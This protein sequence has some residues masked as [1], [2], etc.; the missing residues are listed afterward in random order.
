MT[1]NTTP[2]KPEWFELTDGD[3]P[4]AQ[5]KKVGKKLPAIAVLVTGAVIASGAFFANASEKNGLQQGPLQNE[6]SS[7]TSLPPHD[8]APNSGAPIGDVNGAFDPSQNGSSI[9]PG[10]LPPHK[11]G[12]GITQPGLPPQGMQPPV[13][14]LGGDDDDDRFEHREGGQHHEDDDDDRDGWRDH[15]DDDEDEDEY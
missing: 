1:P 12:A 3:A 9:V 6:M 8:G 14:G 13:P 15:D 7:N 5:V 2:E 11:T 4:S 10:N